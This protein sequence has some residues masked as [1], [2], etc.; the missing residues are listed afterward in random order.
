[1]SSG[2]SLLTR[3]RGSVLVFS[4]ALVGWFLSG[5]LR[6]YLVVA[7]TAP[8]LLVPW[9][10]LR[11][12][13][14]GFLFDLPTAVITVGLCAVSARLFVVRPLLTATSLTTTIWAIDLAL[15]WLVSNDLSLWQDPL[16]LIPRLA[17]GVATALGGARVMGWRRNQDESKDE[18]PE[19]VESSNDG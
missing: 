10:P 11:R 19:E 5:W 14:V 18:D 17:L 1:M 16:T 13:L 15:A 7:M 3:G 4:G 12:V 9:L 6:H 8:V 2:R